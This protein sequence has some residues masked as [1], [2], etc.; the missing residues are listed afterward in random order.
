M[1]NS[2]LLGFSLIA[3]TSLSC[4]KVETDQEKL[5]FSK[6]FQTGRA[7]RNENLELNTDTY[8]LGIKAG[9]A[10]DD[11]KRKPLLSESEMISAEIKYRQQQSVSLGERIEKNKLEGETFLQQNGRRPE[12]KTTASGLQYEVLS[13]GSGQK[14]QSTDIVKAFS[15]GKRLDGVLFENFPN[16]GSSAPNFSVQNQLPG[17]QEA[18]QLMPTGS[19]FRFAV[20]P[21]LGYGTSLR[22]DILPHSVLVYEVELL[23]I[24][25]AEPLA[26]PADKKK[27]NR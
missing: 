20:P 5:S 24:L 8:I 21:H 17:W 18:I 19:K 10:P 22:G 4:Q 6:G 1:K 16:N 9:L 12:V 13:L 26:R 27:A 11:P 7:L 2:A 15:V 23:E 25:A 3:L 14:P